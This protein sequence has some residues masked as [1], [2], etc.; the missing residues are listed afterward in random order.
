MAD[1]Y[2]VHARYDEAIDML[3]KYYSKPSLDDHA[4]AMITYTISEGYRLKGDKQGKNITWLFRPSP[5]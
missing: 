4:Q 3:M 1:K 5:I 2:I